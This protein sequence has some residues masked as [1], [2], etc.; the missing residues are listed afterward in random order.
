MESERL[1]QVYKIAEGPEGLANVLLDYHEK[2]QIDDDFASNDQYI[3]YR[4]NQQKALI[5]ID[6][7]QVPYQFWYYD[8]LGRPAT[9]NI[10]ETIAK[11]LWIICNERMK[12]LGDG[13]R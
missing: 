4:N 5:K 9:N 2:A 8:L 11:F 12:Y 1:P 3:L 7:R 13:K 10:K 6:M